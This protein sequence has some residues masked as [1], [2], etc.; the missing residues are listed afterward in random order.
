M[1]SAVYGVS[2]KIFLGVG[3]M[4]QVKTL[5][6]ILSA[7]APLGWVAVFYMMEVPRPGNAPRP[8]RIHNIFDLKFSAVHTLVLNGELYFDHVLDRNYQGVIS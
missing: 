6:G 2:V 3:I 5:D 4:E 1:V 8:V 7:C